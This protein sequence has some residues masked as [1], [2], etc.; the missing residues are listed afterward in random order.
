MNLAPIESAHATSY[1]SVI[2][3]LVLSC[4]VS[5]ISQ[6]LCAPDPTPIEP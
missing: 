4:T 1:E 5:E 3:T 2:V 6:L